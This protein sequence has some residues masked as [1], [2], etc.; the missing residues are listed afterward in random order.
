LSGVDPLSFSIEEDGTVR[1]FDTDGTE[2]LKWGPP[3][4]SDPTAFLAA[5]NAIRL[6]DMG[7]LD[8]LKHITKVT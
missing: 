1:I 8:Y 6:V 5:L 7:Q 4:Y 3:E 2:I